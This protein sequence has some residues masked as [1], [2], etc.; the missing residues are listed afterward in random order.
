[1]PVDN[2]GNITTTPPAKIKTWHD[3]VRTDKKDGIALQV[4]GMARTPQDTGGGIELGAGSAYVLPAATT[5]AIGGVKKAAAV[6]T[7]AAGADAATIVTTVNDLITKLK[8]A[9]VLT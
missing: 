1:M 9:G 7:L 6:T 4:G 8:A 2:E 5:A 3:V